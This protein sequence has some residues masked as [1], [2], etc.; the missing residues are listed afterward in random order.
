MVSGPRHCAR[1]S[2]PCRT[3]WPRLSKPWTKCTSTTTPTVTQITAL[4]AETKTRSTESDVSIPPSP[5][6]KTPGPFCYT[7]LHPSASPG[8]P[9]IQY[10][11]YK[12]LIN[13]I[14]KVKRATSWSCAVL[15][16]LFLHPTLDS[17]GK[18]TQESSSSSS[19]TWTI[20]NVILKKKREKKKSCRGTA[21][22]R[23]KGVLPQPEDFLCTPLI[24]YELQRMDWNPATP[25]YLNF[26]IVTKTKLKEDEFL[27]VLW[28]IN[29]KNKEKIHR[30]PCH[31]FSCRLSLFSLQA[32][33]LNFLNFNT[34]HGYIRESVFMY[35]YIYLCV[36]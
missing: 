25:L 31:D 13:T 30:A 11:Y 24:F 10:K 8:P 22:G 35:V 2:R 4:K 33:N 32:T 3:I 27:S 36:I 29:L 6:A 1:Q 7:N 9:P 28:I 21:A 17:R 5:R 18:T 34:I 14:D 26:T 15:H 23:G 20:W 12:Y 19:N 16:V